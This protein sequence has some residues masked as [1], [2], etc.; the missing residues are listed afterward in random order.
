MVDSSTKIYYY[1]ATGRAQVVR[2][3]LAAG[4]ITWED[5]HPA[6]FPATDEEKA[7]W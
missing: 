1:K 4:G 3:L 6:G 2:Y 5:K 7:E